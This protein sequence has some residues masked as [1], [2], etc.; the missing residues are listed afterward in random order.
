MRILEKVV[1]EDLNRNSQIDQK[2]KMQK[3]DSMVVGT[4]FL[5]TEG[6]METWVLETAC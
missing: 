1:G 2:V 6:D 4:D 3:L 5:V